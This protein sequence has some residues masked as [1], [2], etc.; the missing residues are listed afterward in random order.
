M[1]SKNI[2]LYAFFVSLIGLVVF[3]YYPAIKG[4]SNEEVF[5]SELDPIKNLSDDDKNIVSK[6]IADY[7][8]KNP[9]SNASSIK[10]L[11]FIPTSF[12]DTSLD[13]KEEGKMYAQV[14][15]PGYKILIKYND[16]VIDYR[17]SSKGEI[18][19]CKN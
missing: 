8:S 12:S 9:E 17:V 14:I 4:S 10:L 2:F 6:V 7:V 11:D 16:K 3:L 18:K 15:T 1:F 5:H 13:C 19:I